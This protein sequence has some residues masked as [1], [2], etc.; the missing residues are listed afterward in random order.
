MDEEKTIGQDEL[1][2]ETRYTIHNKVFL[3]QPAFRSSGDETLGTILWKL[4]CSDID[5]KAEH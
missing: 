2:M 5:G 4:M 3:V 1:E